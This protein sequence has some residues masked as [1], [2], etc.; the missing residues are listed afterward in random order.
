VRLSDGLRTRIDKIKE[1]S[2]AKPDEMSSFLESIDPKV[3]VFLVRLI[4]RVFNDRQSMLDVSPQY[5][6]LILEDLRYLDRRQG[7]TLTQEQAN[8]ERISQLSAEIA[9]L[10]NDKKSLRI[11]KMDMK[12]K[13]QRLENDCQAVI[14]QSERRKSDDWSKRRRDWNRRGYR[15]TRSC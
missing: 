8:S 4:P 15:S 9:V 6:E 5:K 3:Q 1:L 13:I 2:G 12:D 10:K 7:P 14:T 11:D